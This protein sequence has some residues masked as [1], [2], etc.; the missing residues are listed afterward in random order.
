MKR[1]V[2]MMVAV[3]AMV[4]AGVA[5]R[6]R[7]VASP[8]LSATGATAGYVPVFTDIGGDLADSLI[9]EN[10]GT[11]AIGIGTITPTAKLDVAG[12][13]PTVRID[14]YS[15]TPGDSPN[16]NF[17]SGHGTAVSPTQTL[18]GDNLGQFAAAGFNGAAFPGSKVKVTFVATENWTASNNGTAMSFQTTTNGSTSRLSRMFID[19]TGNV[20]IGSIFGTSPATAP[21]FPLTVNGVVQS[22]LGGFRF[23]DNTT[24]VTAGIS[25]V[26]LTSPDSTITVTGSGTAALT[27]A[28]NTG[29]VQARVTGTCAANAAVTSVN[30]DGSVGCGSVGPTGTLASAPVVV[31]TTTITCTTNCFGLGTA[32]TI[33]TPTTTGFYRVSVYMNVPTA[34]TCV[35]APCAGEAIVLQ[36]NDGVSTTALDTANCNLVTVCGS[37]VV[38]PIWVQSGQ[39]ITAYGQI[40][41][42]AATPGGSPSYTAHLLVEQL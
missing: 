38:T 1:V 7:A 17:I 31:A 6:A 28:A 41:G 10:T 22:L 18:N 16:F 34:G 40:Y 27:V 15:D 21:A 33:Y 20:G 8:A 37:S 3:M 5:Q 35:T 26:A 25:G 12:A 30:A 36:W 11:G 19:N 39:A 2:A 9:F 32:Q 14:N 4:G 13:N 42:T 29:K 24:Q 23:P